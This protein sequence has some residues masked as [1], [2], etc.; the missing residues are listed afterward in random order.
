MVSLLAPET[1]RLDSS[2]VLSQSP[3]P[4]WYRW[5]LALLLGNIRSQYS[6]IKLFIH[7][8]MNIMYQVQQCVV[9]S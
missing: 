3:P 9:S 2:Q 5:N 1:I 4:L 7:S 8:E 6:A